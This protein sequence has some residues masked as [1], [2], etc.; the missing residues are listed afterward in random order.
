M[1]SEEVNLGTD[2]D[3]IWHRVA[4][5]AQSSEDP[6]LLCCILRA[7]VM[8]VQEQEAEMKRKGL[9]LSVL[10]SLTPRLASPQIQ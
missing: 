1:P 3:V 10:V 7:E 2:E 9:A 6:R 4:A 8:T 5:R